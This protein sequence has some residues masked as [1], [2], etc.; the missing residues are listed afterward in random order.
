MGGKWHCNIFLLLLGRDVLDT[1]YCPKAESQPS[2]VPRAQENSP[3]AR[4][5]PGS[6]TA[7]ER[8]GD[9][10][11]QATRPTPRG[12]SLGSET[13]LPCLLWSQPGTR[14]SHPSPIRKGTRLR[15][16][17][18][19]SAF[20]FRG[21]LSACLSAG[22]A[23]QGPTVLFTSLRQ[24]L[25]CPNGFRS[26]N[27]YLGTAPGKLKDARVLHSGNSTYTDCL[28][29]RGSPPPAR[30]FWDCIPEVGTESSC[31]RLPRCASQVRSL[32]LTCWES[33]NNKVQCFP[34]LKH[35]TK[36]YYQFGER[37]GYKRTSRIL[38]SPKPSASQ[39][40][41]ADF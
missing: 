38:S 37:W 20:N 9:D 34:S 26:S 31:K 15:L 5:A 14:P 32:D 24:G 8:P 6:K 12:E 11:P 10:F 41:S 7:W 2:V 28:C 39:N 40:P 36:Q 33:K 4:S 23:L 29:P 25:L 21:S 27:A 16:S 19:H 3:A 17:G 35:S 30:S 13:P 22:L 1:T 18:Q